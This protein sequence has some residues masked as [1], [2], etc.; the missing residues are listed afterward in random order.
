MDRTSDSGSE[1][2]GFESPQRRLKNN[3]KR[4]LSAGGIVFDNH[5]Q[6]L[7]IKNAAMR[8]PTKSYW[9]F[10]KGHI[11]VDESSGVAAVRE[12]EEE[13]GIKT[14]IISKLGDSRYVFTKDGEKIF[15][16]VVFFLLEYVAGVLKPQEKEILEVAW[17]D[18]NDALNLLSFEKDR[19]FL[20]KA[21]FV[22]NNQSSL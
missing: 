22:R 15:K 10:P 2:W 18:P 7:V 4:E 19:Q 16:I 1:D 20:Q 17:V 21:L 3:M 13:T 11:E 8:D 14:K 12:V 6:V 5:G 9:G